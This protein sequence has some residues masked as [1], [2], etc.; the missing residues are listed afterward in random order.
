MQCH[1]FHKTKTKTRDVNAIITKVTSRC[2][3]TTKKTTDNNTACYFK[4]IQ[5]RFLLTIV[6]TYKLYLLS[7]IS[8]RKPK[9]TNG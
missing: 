1:S 7:Y 9:S 8:Y 5:I 6:H 4:R 3:E 2:F